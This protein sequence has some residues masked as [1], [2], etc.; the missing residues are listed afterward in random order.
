MAYKRAAGV[1]S[2]VKKVFLDFWIM[3]ILEIVRIPRI[4]VYTDFGTCLKRRA[5][6]ND[7]FW[8]YE[9]LGVQILH[10][11][12]IGEQNDGWMVSVPLAYLN[13]P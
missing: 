4:S 11:D 2:S 5:P 13:V 10:H 12:P 1:F 6:K 3:S 9:D 7:E 8:R